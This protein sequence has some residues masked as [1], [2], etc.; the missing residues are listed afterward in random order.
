MEK[1]IFIGGNRG[2][3]KTKLSLDLKE[4]FHIPYIQYS[5]YNI[6]MAIDRFGELDWSKL[7]EPENAH[8]INNKFIDYVK[9]IRR[10]DGSIIID[11]HYSYYDS[12]PFEKEEYN[13]LMEHSDSLSVLVFASL[14]SAIARIK[15]DRKDRFLDQSKIE[16]DIDWNRKMF[17]YYTENTLSKRFIL[18]NEEFQT[19]KSQLIDRTRKFLFS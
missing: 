4:I 6:R 14:P 8:W 16:Q 12:P 11:G 1:T 10:N 5:E 15:K 17:D 2:V 19:A 18:E 13:R 3:G 7:S 9:K